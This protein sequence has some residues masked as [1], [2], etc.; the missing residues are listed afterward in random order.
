MGDGAAG[1]ARRRQLQR[2]SGERMSGFQTTE[3]YWNLWH[4]AATPVFVPPRGAIDYSSE[5]LMGWD[6][7]APEFSRQVFADIDR[8]AATA[9]GRKL[10]A[11]LA[12]A[13]HRTKIEPSPTS[14]SSG[15]VTDSPMREGSDPRDPRRGAPPT[16]RVHPGEAIDALGLVEQIG[17]D[18]PPEPAWNPTASHVALFHELVHAYHYTTG[19][20]A[21]GRLTAEQAVHAGDVGISMSEY[22]A[23][24]LDTN[25]EVPGTQFA[26]TEEFTEN[27]YRAQLGFPV[28]NAY[29]PG[30][31]RVQTAPSP[32]AFT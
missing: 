19:T 9:I 26:Q 21:G 8:I 12:T 11:F 7:E 13:R 14:L 4:W 23:T 32:L 2:V 22:Q 6:A 16:V 30:G 3:T 25:D 24:G 27:A 28:R 15:P 31:Y 5:M 29:V 18:R 17:H 1:G 10:L 20:S